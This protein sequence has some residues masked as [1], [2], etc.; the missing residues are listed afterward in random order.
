MVTRK[1]AP[2]DGPSR[3]A[4]T[5]IDEYLAPLRPDQRAAV[6]RLREIIQ[7]VAPAA[8][9]C[10]SYRMPAFRI[11][12]KGLMW[13]AAAAKHSAIYGVSES[14]AGEFGAY[15]TSG[16]GTLRFALD[17]PVPAALV[18]RLVKRRLEKIGATKAPTAARPARR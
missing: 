9:E 12:G 14:Y 11:N 15:S 10:I 3:P 6:Q 4:P 18:R 13:F 7:A 17:A 16:R 5:T 1:K 8:E 2:P